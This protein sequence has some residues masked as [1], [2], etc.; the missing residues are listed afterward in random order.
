MSLQGWNRVVSYYARP[1]SFSTGGVNLSSQGW[2]KAI[3]LYKAP[4]LL[5]AAEGGYSKQLVDG[6]SLEFVRISH[7]GRR[8]MTMLPR[9][10]FAILRRTDIVF[11]H[12]GWT[13]SNIVVALICR[14]RSI[15]YVVVPHGV[16]AP[17]LVR[18]LRLRRLRKMFEAWVVR[19]A[20]A[21]HV[22]FEREA[23]EVEE[24]FGNVEC[25]IAATGHRVHDNVTTCSGSG[26]YLS[27]L[28][29]Y[30]INH[31]GIDRLLAA[32]Q[33]LDPAVRPTIVMH[34]PDHRGD[35]E[36]VLE[37]VGKAGLEQWVHVRGELESGKALDFLGGSKGFIHVPRWEAFGHT[38][39]EAMSLSIPVLLS[40]DAQIATLLEA[41]N[42]AIVVSADDAEILGKA[43]L[44]INS[45]DS[46]IGLR[47]REWVVQNLSW[48][49]QVQ[50]LF[51]RLELLKGDA[52]SKS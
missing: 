11:I 39:V 32:M 8:R 7:V 14:L 5:I 33:Y 3:S 41:A 42:A 19:G 51:S 21:V 6:E 38:V 37:L 36:R 31:K 23:N 4:V 45:V 13:P 52:G 20:L 44:E 17:E 18:D 27:W 1:S 35:K 34:G 50:T 40:S 10:M 48:E 43:L 47:G 25:A 22:F 2:M 26:D 9:G 15:S 49:I 46:D 29:R 28:G 12:E 16:Y 30:D 24:L